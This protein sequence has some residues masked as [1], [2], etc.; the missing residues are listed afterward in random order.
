MI[1]DRKG[2]PLSCIVAGA[3]K[4]DF[5]ILKETL[6]ALPQVPQDEEK[7]MCL[8]KGYD[9][10]EIRVLLK[11]KKW[12]PHIRARGEEILEKK[13]RCKP[14]RWVVER[15]HSW[16]NRFRDILIRWC[17]KAENFQSQIY[18]ACSYIVL[19][20]CGLLG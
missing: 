12:V 11:R 3:N 15:T 6:G 2:I 1:T 9:Y 14:K 10:D 19:C 18:L 16:M 4:N 8:D 20:R 17:K 5:K 13:K 7:N